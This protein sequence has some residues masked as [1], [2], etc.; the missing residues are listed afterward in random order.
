MRRVSL[1]KRW[2]A[3]TGLV[4]L[5]AG[6]GLVHAG[7]LEPPGP[8]GSTMQ[9][10][11]RAA[12]LPLSITSPGLYVLE[13]DVDAAG[14]SG[15]L[16]LVGDVTI[17]LRGHSLRNGTGDGIV[18]GAVIQ[19]VA[20][21]NGS[22]SGWSSD[23]VDLA[24]AADSQIVG[25]RSQG[26]GITGIRIGAGGLVKECT[27]RG[28]G[29]YGIEAVGS[30]TVISESVAST[31]TQT[32]IQLN[33]GPTTV[34]R[35]TSH[36]NGANGIGGNA[37]VATVTDCAVRDN[38]TTG[39]NVSAGSLVSRCTAYGNGTSGAGDGI[40][41]ST[42]G[43]VTD[44]NASQNQEDGIQVGFDSLVARNNADSNGLQVVGAGIHVTGGGSRIEGNNVTDNDR[45]ILVDAAGNIVIKNSASGNTFEYTVPGG[46]VFGPIVSINTIAGSTNPH[47][48]YEF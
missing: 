4:A 22:V 44:C 13:E 1:K 23:G 25:I 45:G 20:V 46:N 21:K 15:I 48:N 19:N 9:T 28:N 27:A 32:G 6:S 42:A 35:C 41:V 3:A 16:I 36:A 14:S 38:G 10:A 17:D 43:S 11:I 12:S 8:V 40:A 47:A 34:T 37:G 31:N 29:F 24:A 7:Q 39:I 33:T 30:G 5:V 18:A 2:I 26:N